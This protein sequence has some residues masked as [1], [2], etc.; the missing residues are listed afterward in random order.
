MTLIE[1]L[2]WKFS[3]LQL[4]A[5]FSFA[6]HTTIG[7]GGVAEVAAFPTT[8]ELLFLL[9]YLEQENIAYCFL[10]AGANVLPQDDF[11]HGVVV[12]F[13]KM[14]RICSDQEAIFAGAGVTGGRLCRYATDHALSGFEAFSGI[15]MTV[16][17]ATVMNAGISDRHFSDVVR[18]VFAIERGK[19][20]KF[21]HSDCEFW[22]KQSAFM[23][24]I[25][26]VGVALQG[27]QRCKDEI[28]RAACYYRVKRA[29]LPHGRSMGCTF[30]NPPSES[31]GRLIEAC[32]LKGRRI[33]RAFV[34]DR[35]ANFIINEGVFS[36]DVK[37]LIALIK[38]EVKEKTGIVL[39]EEIRYLP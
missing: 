8:H 31:A 33:G 32:G 38:Q 20:K 29:H 24:G 37:A 15:P 23:N 13:S 9:R 35:H 27:A 19:I 14:N 18:F 11:F 26:V 6:R 30:V 7:C 3:H 1:R 36:K 34:S 2:Q 4:Q 16:G 12:C 28:V 10:G 39:R 25:A 21:S 17:G 22:E 5:N